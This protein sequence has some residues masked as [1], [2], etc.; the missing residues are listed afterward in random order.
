MEAST[1]K[2]LPLLDLRTK[3]VP[4]SCATP[5]ASSVRPRWRPRPRRSAAGTSTDHWPA[6]NSTG[7]A[8]ARSWMRVVREPS[9]P[10]WLEVELAAPASSATRRA[11][12]P[13]GAPRAVGGTP[14]CPGFAARGPGEGTRGRRPGP[15]RSSSAS[16]G[17][18]KEGSP[19]ASRRTPTLVTRGISSWMSACCRPTG[20]TVTGPSACRGLP[21]CS[22]ASSP[23]TCEHL[24]APA[25]RRA[26]PLPWARGL[27]CPAARSGSRWSCVLVRHDHRVEVTHPRE[28]LG[29][30]TGVEEGSGRSA[31]ST[32]RQACPRWVIR[33]HST[34][35]RVSRRRARCGLCASDRWGDDL[36]TP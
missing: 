6:R 25:G 2:F 29:E 30:S 18:K 27:R 19:S 34:V 20:V 5:P 22:R 17:W 4:A 1:T 8:P 24:H 11:R 31:I 10:A 21:P 23:C 35:C 9:C 12:A 32:R 7:P 26:R 13:R 14:S 16:P 36:A 15:A 33:I 28:V 3:I